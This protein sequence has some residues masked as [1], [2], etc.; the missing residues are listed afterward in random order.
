M[1]AF[2][3]VVLGKN[4]YQGRSQ[5]VRLKYADRVTHVNLI[6]KSGVG[7]STL[8]HHM[9]HQDIAAGKGVAVIDPH[10]DLID[11]ILAYISHLS[12]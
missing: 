8:L 12:N 2:E 9:V 5:A 6:G 10:G 3:G 7:K 4:T 1:G 11:D